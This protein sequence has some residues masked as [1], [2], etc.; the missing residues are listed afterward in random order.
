MRLLATSLSKLDCG[1]KQAPIRYSVLLL[2]SL[3]AV[4]DALFLPQASLYHSSFKKHFEKF[5]EV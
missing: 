5:S 2:A 3:Y 4:K 1:P